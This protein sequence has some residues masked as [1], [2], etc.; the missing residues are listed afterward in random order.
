MSTRVARP[1]SY[2][3]KWLKTTRTRNR[4]SQKGPKPEP[5]APCTCQELRALSHQIAVMDKYRKMFNVDGLVLE[6]D[7]SEE[8]T[9]TCRQVLLRAVAASK[10]MWSLRSNCVSKVIK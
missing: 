4:G 9:T 8:G 3:Y 2:S 7:L 6:D 5:K 1:Y 10:F